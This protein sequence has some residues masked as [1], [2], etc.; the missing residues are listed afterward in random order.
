M[1]TDAELHIFV[2]DLIKYTQTTHDAMFFGLEIELI[3][4]ALRIYILYGY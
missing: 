2:R 4:E 3:L 1:R